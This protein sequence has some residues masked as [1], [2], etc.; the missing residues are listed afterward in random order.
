[1]VPPV[2][3]F[4]GNARNYAASYSPLLTP[5]HGEIERVDAFPIAKPLQSLGMAQRAH[6]V[7]ITGGPMLI[8]RQ[9][10]RLEILRVSLIV[11]GA[12]GQLD[13]VGRDNRRAR[14]RMSVTAGEM[15]P[16]RNVERLRNG[17]RVTRLSRLDRASEIFGPRLAGGARGSAICCC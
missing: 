7:V 9:P 5:V 10:G 16:K 4:D 13:K 12:I 17:G 2:S 6:C 8:H 14:L 1:M 15:S 11:L 3:A